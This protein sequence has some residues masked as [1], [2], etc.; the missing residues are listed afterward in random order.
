MTFLLLSHRCCTQYHS[1]HTTREYRRPRR[2]PTTVRK[3]L[4]TTPAETTPGCR[5]LH[6]SILV[7][8]PK[9]FRSLWIL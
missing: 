6:C 2:L 8:S 3:W 1:D 9:H 5:L 4:W 7:L